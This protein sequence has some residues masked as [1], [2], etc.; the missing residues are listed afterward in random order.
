M[1]HS[2]TDLGLALLKMG[3]EFP[4]DGEGLPGRTR[5]GSPSAALADACA[6]FSGRSQSC[7]TLTDLP[8]TPRGTG[9]TVLPG[10]PHTTRTS[11]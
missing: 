5:S 9:R 3:E 10:S 8:R 1:L 6:S 11:V 2:L 7:P 4:R